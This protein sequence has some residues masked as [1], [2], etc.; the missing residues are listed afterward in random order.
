MDSQLENILLARAISSMR[1][2]FAMPVSLWFW[3]YYFLAKC[4]P[5]GYL[6]LTAEENLT[7][8]IKYYNTFLLKK[9]LYK[10]YFT[11]Y[12]RGSHVQLKELFT[13]HSLINGEERWLFQLDHLNNWI[14]VN[15]TSI[16][17]STL[18]QTAALLA[19]LFELDKALVHIQFLEHLLS[20]M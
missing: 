7:F 19:R 2:I 14:G 17:N 8:S 16:Q 20:K 3:S 18:E 9:I 15:N 1:K 13:A 6:V 4:K 11:T 10:T 12:W 5:F